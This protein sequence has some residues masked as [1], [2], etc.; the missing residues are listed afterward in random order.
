MKKCIFGGPANREKQRGLMNRRRYTKCTVS[1]KWHFFSF[2]VDSTH[3]E[4]SRPFLTVHY[5]PT[6]YISTNGRYSFLVLAFIHFT[7]GGFF[8]L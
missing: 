3:F 1:E 6:I 4:P 8:I 5:L 2:S 7:R